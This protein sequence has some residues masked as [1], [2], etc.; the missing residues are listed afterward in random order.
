MHDTLSAV[1]V[2]HPQTTEFFAPDTVIQQGSQDRP[3]CES[4]IC[5]TL[6]CVELNLGASASTEP[7][8]WF[9]QKPQ[10]EF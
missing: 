2:L 10:L 4:V 6:Q 7:S 9:T 8:F 1:Q 3:I 5:T